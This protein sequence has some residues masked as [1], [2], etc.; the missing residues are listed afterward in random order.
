MSRRDAFSFRQ[1]PSG[2][3]KRFLKA[4]TYLFRWKLGFLFGDRFLMLTHLGRTSGRSYR[5]V[6]EVVHHDESS[7]EYVVCS[8]T[9]PNAD[10]YRN[11]S[12]RPA[13]SIQV[14]NEVWTPEQRMLTA[15]EAAGMFADYEARHP[16]AARRLL[17][18]MGQS[19]DGSDA[20]RVRMAGNL[21]MVAFRRSGAG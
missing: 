3:F 16:K 4:P 17:A 9:G 5:T 21:P 18:S 12:A 8:G 20:D 19:Y 10:W 11:I 15:D 6:L 7:G 2:L 14:R 1:R 13:M